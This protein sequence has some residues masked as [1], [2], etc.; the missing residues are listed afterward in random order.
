MHDIYDI[1]LDQL[2][3][4]VNYISATL[5]ETAKATAVNRSL[6]LRVARLLGMN[7]KDLDLLVATAERDYLVAMNELINQSHEET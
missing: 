3:K 2:K 5:A 1:P 7:T 6:V 4:E